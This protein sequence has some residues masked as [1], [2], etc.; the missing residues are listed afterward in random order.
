MRWFFLLSLAVLIS[1]GRPLTETEAAFTTQ[2]LGSSIDTGRIRLVEGALIGKTTYTR[3]KRPRIAC[4]ERIFPPQAEE[5]KE[6]TVSP[7]A[8]VLFS[9]VFY[10]RDWYLKDYL[11]D[12]DERFYL[13]EAM[14]FAHEMTHVWQ[15]QNRRQTGYS[16]LKAL[17]EHQVSDDPYLFD[18]GTDTRFLDYGY[19][20]QA[21]IVEEY[22][23]CATL[24]PKAPR[25]ARL[26]ELLEGAFPLGK[27]T[28]PDKVV[29]PW[30]GAE[31]TGICR[32]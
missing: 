2:I 28:L 14:L 19:E 5:T 30:D 1:C 12:Y 9:K 29:L 31:L 17:R 7:A 25:T 13:V 10:S 8:F 16:P 23:C 26:K 3:K 20:Q 27:L 4:R 6:V 32:V 15:W 11:P 24:D 22:V 21:S 18:V